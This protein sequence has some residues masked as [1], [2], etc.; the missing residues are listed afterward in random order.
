MAQ[1]DVYEYGLNDV[2]YLLDIQA[3]ILSDLETHVCIPLIKAEAGIDR[4]FHK[5]KPIITINDTDYILVTT[6]LTVVPKMM[7]KKATA[8]LEQRYYLTIQSA[9]DFLFQG[10]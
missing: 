9:L 3:E 2:D 5:L 6:D 7:L 10:V 1:F 4:E 8:N